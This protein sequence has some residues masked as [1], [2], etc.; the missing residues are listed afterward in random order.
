MFHSQPIR[1]IEKKRSHSRMSRGD[2]SFSIFA[3][4]LVS[5]LTLL[6]LL[7]MLN[8]LS[9]SFSSAAAVNAGRVLLWP[10][11]PTLKNYQTIFGYRSVWLGYRNTIFYTVAGT[12]INVAMTML[13][14]YPLAQKSFSGRK[15]FSMMFF[16]PMIFSGGMIPSY[17]LMRDLR[18][19]NSVWVMLLPG[20][21][22]ITNMIITRTFIQTTIPESVAEAAVLDGCSPARYFISFVLP[23][24]KTILAV[25]SMY[26]AVGH[27]NDYFNAFLYLNNRELYPLQLFLR[28][29][30]VNSQFDSSVMNDPEAAQQLQGLADTLKYVIIVVATLPLMCV[31]P[32]VQKY[33]V[34]GVMIGSVKG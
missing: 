27:W 9:A 23:L 22:S 18:L 21:I 6:V 11:D 15:F 29:I 31:Y 4:V 32:F 8:V 7:P 19:L 24:S 26:Y 2:R 25:I 20:A 12:L 1:R 10:V 34:K 30:L 33:F 17:I 3:I 28:E 14:A 16:V 5:L 13:C